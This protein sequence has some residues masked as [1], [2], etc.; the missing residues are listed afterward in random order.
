MWKAELISSHG[1]SVVQSNIIGNTNLLLIRH[2]MTSPTLQFVKQ[3]L[4]GGV[5]DARIR[6]SFLKLNKHE[7][8]FNKEIE[9]IYTPQMAIQTSKLDCST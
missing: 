2:S 4:G 7:L 5:W 3:G 9:H 1:C 8:R 6:H